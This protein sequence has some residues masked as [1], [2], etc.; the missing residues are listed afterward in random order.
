MKTYNINK[1]FWERLNEHA[2]KYH[3][4]QSRYALWLSEKYNKKVD[5]KRLE[6][7]GRLLPKL[8]IE[9]IE[10]FLNDDELF[11]YVNKISE[12]RDDLEDFASDYVMELNISDEL[13]QYIR[14]KRKKQR[15]EMYLAI[16]KENNL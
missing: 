16:D 1:I 7:E 2:K 5:L 13:R 10:G 4:C 9:D 12:N 15:D 6:R 14:I 11:L 3:Q 8:F